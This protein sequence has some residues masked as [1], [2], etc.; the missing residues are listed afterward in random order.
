MFYKDAS[1]CCYGYLMLFR[2]AVGKENLNLA[3]HGLSLIVLHC[4]RTWGGQNTSEYPELP[5]S[6]VEG[7]KRGPDSFCCANRR[8]DS[9]IRVR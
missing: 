1:L 9:F 5:S 6:N 3:D 2:L 8:G 7:K 4:W